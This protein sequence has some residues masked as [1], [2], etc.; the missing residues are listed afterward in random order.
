MSLQL[1]ALSWGQYEQFLGG[2][3]TPASTMYHHP[4]WLHSVQDGLG[5]RVVILGLFDETG[6]IGVLPGFVARKGPVGLFGSPLRGSMTPHL[7]W[8]SLPGRQ[9]P[10]EAALELL[11]CFCTRRLH[12]QYVE[13]TL[14]SC[15]A[16]LLSGM[17]PRGWNLEQPA[18]YV[19]DLRLGEEVLWK[20]LGQRGRNMVTRA[21]KSEVVI[22]PVAGRAI[23]DEFFAML[24]ASFARHHA[25]PPHPKAFYL[26][27]W[28]HLFPAGRM[29]IFAAR[30]H[31]RNLAIG[32]FMHDGRE[33][34]FLSGGSL[35]ECHGLRPNNLLHWYV[36]SRSAQRG[37]ALY[38]LGGKGVPSIDTFKESFGPSVQVYSTF[39]RASPPLA[40]ARNL[41]VR[42][43]P[44]VLSLRY[45]V[46]QALKPRGPQSNS[47]ARDSAVGAA[48][49]LLPRTGL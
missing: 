19:V 22:E 31:G 25:V 40:L 42:A 37:L 43:L 5:M 6:L 27:L 34:H 12:C 7:G 10:A 16:D 9:I 32:L 38:D 33:I 24:E 18:T 47:P 1:Q 2:S 21:R 48:S 28:D 46:R 13:V 15:P 17:T 36:I 8:L 11:Y 14:A 4:L 41:M 44:H 49:G 45:R 26:A 35:A 23:V 20:N 30:Q 39:W 3:D 29:E